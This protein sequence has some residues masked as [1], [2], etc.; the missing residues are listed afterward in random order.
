M[1][2]ISLTIDGRAVTVETGQTV[3][4]AAR[5]LGIDIPTLCY[6]ERCGPMTSCLACLVK[7][8]ANGQGKLVPSCAT[9]AQAGMVI[10]SETD[11]VFAARRTALELLLSDHVGDCL[12]PCHRICPLHLNIPVMI[13]HIEA[14]QLDEAAKVVRDALPM[15]SILGRL[16]HKPCEHGCR[17]SA[18]DQP[19]SIRDMERFVADRD[20]QMQAADSPPP[21]PLSGKSVAI[22]GAGPAG[23]AA[24]DRLVRE[25][26][27]CTVVDRHPLPGGSLRAEVLDGRLDGQVLKT[28][29]ARILK[30]GVQ[31]KLS[32]ELGRD[33]SIEGLLRGFDAVLLATGEMNMADAERLGLAAGPAGIEADPITW[34]TSVNRVFAT[35]S[36]VKPVKQL[37]RAMAEGVH[38]A[39]LIHQYLAA[40]HLAA[41]HKPFSSMMGRLEEG[42]LKLFLEGASTAP[43]VTPAG[44]AEAGFANGEA[45]AEAARCLHCDCRAAGNCGLQHYAET[46]R[47]VPGR[48]KAERRLFVQH[49]QHGHVLFEPGKCILCGICVKLTEQA[50][51]PLGLT[52]V[53]RGFDVHIAAP[54][55]HTIAEG[56]QKVARECVEACPT[57]ALSFRSPPQQVRCSSNSP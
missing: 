33:I 13:R 40:G 22:I 45:P 5:K 23:L 37:V 53:G 34:Q 3:L 29:V 41:R 25:G 20:L 19:A 1:S 55:N 47:A 28:E 50:G 14:N 51:E 54:L 21:K 10:E 11:E 56:L 6:L 35:G 30:A 2:I 12:S 24:A 38:A 8:Q 36:A 17:R 42:E 48:F 18:C 9:K 15:P 26:H 4:D 49:R 39:A 44:G 31:L 7:V 27:A 43:R 57:G 46:Y 16:C 32:V 52:F